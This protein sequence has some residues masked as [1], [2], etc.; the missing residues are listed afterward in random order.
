MEYLH[1]IK[2]GEVI[3]SKEVEQICTTTY[4]TRDEFVEGA[5]IND[6]KP[7]LRKTRCYSP[8]TMSAIRDSIENMSP[9]NSVKDSSFKEII[10]ERCVST[11]I[12]KF[13]LVAFHNN[14]LH[15][16][17]S[18]RIKQREG[19]NCTVNFKGCFYAARLILSSDDKI[20]LS[21]MK[22]I[23]AVQSSSVKKDEN[24]I[25]QAS[26][27]ST[28]NSGCPVPGYTK[29][30]LLKSPSSLYIEEQQSEDTDQGILHN[31][32]L[33]DSVS[34]SVENLSKKSENV[35]DEGH[36]SSLSWQSKSS[37]RAISTDN[38]FIEIEIQTNQMFEEHTPLI[39]QPSAS[40]PNKH[41]TKTTDDSFNES[42]SFNLGSH[43]NSTTIETYGENPRLTNIQNNLLSLTNISTSQANDESSSGQ[44]YLPDS[45]MEN[46]TINA[47]SFL[48][49]SDTLNIAQVSVPLS[50]QKS[51]KHFCIF[52]KTLQTKIARHLFLKHKGEKLVKMAMALPKKSK[53]RLQIIDKLRKQGDFIHN[54]S[55]DQNTGTLIVLRRQQQNAKHNPDDYVCCPM[56]K[57]FYRKYT[58][59]AHVRNCSKKKNQR[60]NFIEGRKLTQYLHPVANREMKSSIFPVLR[61]DEVSQAIRY[62]ELIIRYGN[63]LSEKLSQTHHHDQIRSHMRLLGRFKIELMKLEPEITELKEMFKPFFFDQAIEALRNTAKWDFTKGFA[64]PAV[65]TSLTSLIKKCAKIQG[66]EFIKKQQND[67]KT[68]LDNFVSLWVDET[69][70]QINR[71]AIEDRENKR[72]TKKVNLPNKKDIKLLYDFLRSKML[73]SIGILNKNFCFQAW[74][75]L[76]EATLI[77]IQV[78]NRRR[79][80][81]IERLTIDNF[82]NKEEI[83]NS[84]EAGLLEKMSEQSIKFAKQFVRISLRGK[85]GR[86]VGVLL[87]PMCLKSINLIIKFRKKAGI[88][89]SNPYIFSA[90]GKS[91]LAK[92]YYRACPLLS[93]FA[94]ECGASFPDDLRGTKLRKHIATYT[95]LL[96]VQESTVERLANFLGHHKD[97]H[98]SIYRIPVPMA[99]ITTVSKILLSA[100]GCNVNNNYKDSTQDA[101]CF[102]PECPEMPGNTEYGV[103]DD[104]SSISNDKSSTSDDESSAFEDVEELQDINSSKERKRSTSPFGKTRRVRWTREEREAIESIFGDPT[105]LE[106]LPTFKQCADAVKHKCLNRRTP[107]QIKTW[108]N[109]QQKKWQDST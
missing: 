7:A 14:E 52:C 77:C 99:E 21:E 32:A 11:R 81:E 69:P 46:T 93:K 31:S 95:S 9:N 90:P 101:N 104:K 64:T 88:R 70:T 75:D 98:K 58:A 53:D 43:K 94:S 97:I 57:G 55:R 105:T 79:A 39:K 25:H 2:E 66:N 74:K 26:D 102:S 62:D 106:K 1:K 10:E 34:S 60:S 48:E 71:K 80:G 3:A 45:T 96:N 15:I 23:Y 41:D 85:L 65:A 103:L 33:Y 30:M 73:R 22:D 91:G 13:S 107:A 17:D 67:L 12:N 86:T 24:T 4:A 63:R 16:V 59:R 37:P 87:D 83:T 20:Y 51:K 8:S 78:F 82:N 56:C 68:L 108:I 44:E 5:Q 38:I 50:N 54:T 47:S 84:V 49:I 42:S 29:P 109:N 19:E 27:A 28:E 61:N 89:E 92:M 40:K 35:F 36:N 100:A 6:D 76:V 18:K 72:R